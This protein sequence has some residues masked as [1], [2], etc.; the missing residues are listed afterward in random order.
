MGEFEST[1]RTTEIVKSVAKD[2]EA[3]EH[4][5]KECGSLNPD[6]GMA[7]AW[8]H[9]YSIL[10]SDIAASLS[11]IA[12]ELYELRKENQNAKREAES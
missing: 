11:L 7:I 2:F 1:K 6:Q 9:S 10:L 8:N 3:I 5:A 4:I 12:D